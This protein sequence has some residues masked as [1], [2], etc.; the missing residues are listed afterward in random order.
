MLGEKQQAN[1][2]YVTFLS[3]IK[4]KQE[5]KLEPNRLSLARSSGGRAGCKKTGFNSHA[6]SEVRTRDTKTLHTMQEFSKHYTSIK[7][8]PDIATKERSLL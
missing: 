3:G 5:I 6:R 4:C 1:F 8:W 2:K 7:G